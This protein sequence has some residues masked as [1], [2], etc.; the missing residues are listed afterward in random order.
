M[1]DPSTDPR[2]AALERKYDATGHVYDVLDWP[3]ER[4]YR[5]WRPALVGDVHGRVLEAGVGTGHNLRHYP[6]DVNLH[7]VDLSRV[8][9]ARARHRARAAACEPTLERADA[10]ELGHLPS[11]S[12]DWYVAT[13]LY[14]VLPDELQPRALEEM[15]RLL[16]PGGR[17]RMVEI[18]YSENPFR[19][20]VQRLLA[21]LVE[22][23]YGARFDRRT[24]RHLADTPGIE[25]ADVRWLKADTHCLIEGRATG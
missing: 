7:A 20:A 24:R 17:F 25:V 1:S 5:K 6:P 19:R 12:F 21:P 13:F 23:L 10:L 22:R 18:V 14:C 4:Q 16:K 2:T 8:M 3:W 11:G 9:L 15:A